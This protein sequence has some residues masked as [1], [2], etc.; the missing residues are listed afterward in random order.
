MREEERYD[1]VQEQM[2]E[3]LD[4]ATTD[5]NPATNMLRAMLY[6]ELFEHNELTHMRVMEARTEFV[7]TLW[8]LIAKWGGAYR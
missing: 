7:G 1:I 3:L 2:R 8:D 5:V 6:A 4:A